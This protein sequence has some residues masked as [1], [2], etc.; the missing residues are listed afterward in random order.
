[1]LK[2]FA[3]W[4]SDRRAAGPESEPLLTQESGQQ[5][6]TSSTKKTTHV[7]F[8][9]LLLARAAIVTDIVFYALTFSTTSGALF[10]VFTAGISFGTSF[11]PTMQSLALDLYERHGGADT[12]RVLG[13]LTV[14]SAL[15]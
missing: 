6:D 15:R 7:A 4:W 5:D 13:A 12:G 14:I 2:L 9:D 8:L 11:T 10:A 1:M 3:W